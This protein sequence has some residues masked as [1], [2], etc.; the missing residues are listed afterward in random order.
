MCCS[1]IALNFRGLSACMHAP[2]YHYNVFCTCRREEKSCKRVVKKRSRAQAHSAAH[3]PLRTKQE[4][5]DMSSMK[6]FRVGPE[7]KKL[8]IF[9]V[10]TGLGDMEVALV[11]SSTKFIVASCR[12]CVPGACVT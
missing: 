3:A 2:H 4:L 6:R 10:Y 12:T 8:H 5:L 7:P 9:S 1:G 11:C